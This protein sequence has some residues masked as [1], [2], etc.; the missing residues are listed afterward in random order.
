MT[1]ALGVALHI[2]LVDTPLR[3]ARLCC[4]DSAF[5]V[6]LGKPACKT[7]QKTNYLMV[8][9]CI[10]RGRIRETTTVKCSTFWSEA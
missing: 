10:L 1:G 5:D 6:R 8:D 4:L 9:C 3:L 2:Q 7:R